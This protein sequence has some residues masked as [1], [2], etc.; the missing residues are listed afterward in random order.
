MEFG[1]HRTLIDYDKRNMQIKMYIKSRQKEFNEFYCEY[2]NSTTTPVPSQHQHSPEPSSNTKETSIFYRCRTKREKRNLAT[3]IINKSLQ[4]GE[5][6]SYSYGA[7][8]RKMI[9]WAKRQKICDED[10]KTMIE[11]IGDLF[12]AGAEYTLDVEPV[13]GLVKNLREEL[14]KDVSHLLNIDGEWVGS[15]DF[16]TPSKCWEDY[17]YKEGMEL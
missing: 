8:R 5:N 17:R 6:E 1:S 13:A 9:K 12:R 2:K 11:Y 7:A 4:G 3:L 14:F 10:T 15:L 16:K